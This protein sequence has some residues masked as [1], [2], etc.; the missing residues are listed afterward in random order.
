M[1]ENRNVPRTRQEP[2][3]TAAPAPQAPKPPTSQGGGFMPRTRAVANVLRDEVTAPDATLGEAAKGFGALGVAGVIDAGAGVNRLIDA[4]R[5]QFGRTLDI[6]RPPTDLV[7]RFTNPTAQPS[8]VAAARGGGASAGATMQNYLTGV[9]GKRDG[10]TFNVPNNDP[11]G[12]AMAGG[13]NTYDSTYALEQGR[14]VNAIRQQTIDAQPR[15]AG[16]V[17]PE[18]DDGSAAMYD[19]AL[20]LRDQ[21]GRTRD[22][23]KASALISQARQLDGM[24]ERASMSKEADTSLQRMM[25]ELQAQ[26]PLNDARA[27]QAEAAGIASL[28]PEQQ[29]KQQFKFSDLGSLMES[30]LL[31]IDPD[32]G[33]PDFSSPMGQIVMSLMGDSYMPGANMGTVK[34]AEGGMVSAIQSYADGGMVTPGPAMPQVDVLQ[35]YQR[36]AQG[37]SAMGLPP[38]PFEQFM[39]MQTAAGERGAQGQ[40]AAAQAPGAIQMAAG[41]QVPDA[42][43]KMIVDTDP[44]APTDSIP[45]MID[46]EQPAALD[47][48]EFV[49][50]KDVVM[51]YGLDKLN[52]MI[53]KAKESA[54]GG[55]EQRP[56]NTAGGGA[57]AIA[58]ALGG[59]G[60]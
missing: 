39:Q 22:P 40:S 6:V 36:Y 49:I 55:S 25:L 10:V 47:S 44:N 50:P 17:M 51:F 5:Q 46:G 13:V 60:L 27:F 59:Q 43:G 16:I 26:Q 8:A 15:G 42:S 28:T 19:R 7:T 52:K 21:A 48:G 29:A 34:M 4:G 9:G 11:N 3:R 37:S 57:S 54:N 58:A 31:P 45:A 56:G 18:A 23:G 12:A 41:G 1:A 53:A 33:Q 32:T 14:K 35:Q 38:V 2:Q 24:A 20:R 30:G